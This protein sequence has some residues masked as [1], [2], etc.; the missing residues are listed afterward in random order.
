MSQNKM[1][2]VYQQPASSYQKWKDRGI[3]TIYDFP[4]GHERNPCWREADRLGLKV[5]VQPNELVDGN[6]QNDPMVEGWLQPDEPENNNHVPVVNN[7]RDY[8][9]AANKYVERYQAWKVKYPGVKVYGNFNGM[10]IT[11][12]REDWPPNKPPSERYCLIPEYRRFFEGADVIGADWFVRNTGR[13]SSQ[14]EPLFTKTVQRVK[15]WSGSKPFFLFIECGYQHRGETGGVAPTP[16]DVEEE[17][18]LA[19][20]L[21]AMGVVYFPA[22]P[23]HGFEF[24]T[25]TPEIVTVMKRVNAK[26]G[27]PATPPIDDLTLEV[28]KSRLDAY[29]KWADQM[30]KF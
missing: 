9:G 15:D 29:K 13:T 1:I 26:Y 30:P 28:A 4:E 24:D 2:G 11:A 23:L 6:V 16:E 14:I 19:F 17:V 18:D 10:N 8:M 20:G 7:V 21:G 25:T 12:T 3:N 27:T 22:R 5:V